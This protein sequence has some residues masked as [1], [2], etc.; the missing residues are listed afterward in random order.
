MSLPQFTQPQCT[1]CASSLSPLP[2]TRPCH[3]DSSHLVRQRARFTQN[4]KLTVKT[5]VVDWFNDSRQEET[6]HLDLKQKME[7][8][9]KMAS[10]RLKKHKYDLQYGSTPQTPEATIVSSQTTEDKQIEILCLQIRLAELTRENFTCASL[11][12]QIPHPLEELSTPSSGMSGLSFF[13]NQSQGF[14]DN[15]YPASIPH[16]KVHSSA[17]DDIGTNVVDFN[18]SA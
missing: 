8:D 15:N 1:S 11:S 3:E 16:P 18:F 13:S 9:E 12:S 14:T 10:M 6:C 5:T 2:P 4:G 7:H 17:S